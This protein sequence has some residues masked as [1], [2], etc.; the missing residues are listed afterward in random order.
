[1]DNAFNTLAMPGVHSIV[2]KDIVLVNES[3]RSFAD[4]YNFNGRMKDMKT[5][6][7]NESTLNLG[8]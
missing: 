8:K 6:R 2:S 7:N 3:H 1:M 4:P 5:Y